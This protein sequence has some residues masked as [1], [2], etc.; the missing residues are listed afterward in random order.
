MLEPVA[1]AR[2]SAVAWHTQIRNFTR[3]SMQSRYGDNAFYTKQAGLAPQPTY[4]VTG[5]DGVERTLLDPN[6]LSKDGTIAVASMDPS[7]NGNVVA[8]TLSEAGSDQMTM[9]FRDVT[10]G[11]D[12]ADSL[13][14]LRNAYATWDPDGKG[15]TYARQVNDASG[16]EAS[17]FALFHHTIGQPQSEDVMFYKRADVPSSFIGAYRLTEHDPVLF[18]SVYSGTDPSA[19]VYFQRPGESRMNEILPPLVASLTPVH[20]NGDSLLAVTDLNAPRN[21]I[22]QIDLRNPAKE[23]WKTLVPESSDPSD[24]LTG[25][26]IAGGKLMV[27]RSKGG[28]DALEVRDMSGAK[29]GD[30]SLPLASKVDFGQVR[31][32]DASFDVSIRG[33]LSPG[34]RYRY[35]VADNRLDF[36]KKSD[37]PRDLTGIADV[38]R[39]FATSKDGTK[40]PMWIVKPKNAKL[41]GTNPTLL[42]SYGGFNIPL[43]PRFDYSMAHWIER[44]GIYVVANLRG[45]GEFGK[46]WYDGGRLANKQNTFDDLAATARELVAQGYTNPTKLAISGGSNGGLTTAVTSQQHPELFGAVI[47]AVPVTDMLRFHTADFGEAW[48]SDY[49]D[50]AKKEDFES[51]IKYS[52]LHNVESAS[53]VAYPPTLILTA[54]HDDRVAPWHAFKWGATRHDKGQLDN[55]FIR[56][57]ERAGHG[58]GKPTQK[59]IE[60]AADEYAF[61][62]KSLGLRFPT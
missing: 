6:S 11:K 1:A 57:E 50:P 5:R 15:V 58:G 41:D 21:R 7:P 36:V 42:Y 34:T 19:G 31:P 29:L 35:S 54:D 39:R 3:E 12:I 45:G 26:F 60:Q 47:S 17:H 43:E 56:T 8:Y 25:A 62:V 52:P 49:G 59:V 2:A 18:S 32:T 27:S 33:F 13:S 46:A 23:G 51:S 28:A 16:G 24:V 48:K 20:R 4:F 9:R 53:R 44:G 61:L 10:T 38:E 14:G 22:V 40:V 37:I 30:V 55:T